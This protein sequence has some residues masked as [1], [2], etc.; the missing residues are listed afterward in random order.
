MK[1]PDDPYTIELEDKLKQADR[2]V[3][4]LRKERDDP[5]ALVTRMEENVKDSRAMIDRWTEAFDMQSGA[6]GNWQVTSDHL[7]AGAELGNRRRSGTLAL[8]TVPEKA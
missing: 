1:K 8:L 6:D 2:R 7:V 5:H 3:D 4:E